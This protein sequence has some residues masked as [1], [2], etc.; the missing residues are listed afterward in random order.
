MNGG[1]PGLPSSYIPSGIDDNPVHTPFFVFEGATQFIMDGVHAHDIG[2]IIDRA[3]VAV[4]VGHHCAQPVMERFG[5]AAT[6][7]ASFG[8]YNT[9]AEVDTLVEALGAVREFFG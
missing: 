4:R 3:G 6:A 7:R 8:L 9:P 5:I 2:T 1:I